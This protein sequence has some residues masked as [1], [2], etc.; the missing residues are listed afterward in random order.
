LAG[1]EEVVCCDGVVEG[2]ETEVRLVEGP[3]GPV[4]GDP[5]PP[6]AA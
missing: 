4:F 3:P 5:P 1:H 6:P 2:E